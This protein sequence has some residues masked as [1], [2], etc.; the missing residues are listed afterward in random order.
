MSPGIGQTNQIP[1][2]G[3]GLTSLKVDHCQGA[4]DVVGTQDVAELEI[5]VGLDLLQQ[6]QGLRLP[7]ESADEPFIA[8]GQMGPCGRQVP[9]GLPDGRAAAFGGGPR[10][11]CLVDAAGQRADPLEDIALLP[12]ERTA[13][14][15]GRPGTDVS[16]TALNFSS[17]GP[18]GAGP[19]RAPAR[20][21]RR[22]RVFACARS[23]SHPQPGG[24]PAAGP[25]RAR[26][27]T[28]LE[29]VGCPPRIRPYRAAG[30][31]ADSLHT[32]GRKSRG[33]PQSFEPEG[34]V[35]G[36]GKRKHR[37]LHQAIEWHGCSKNWPRS[38][39]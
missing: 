5:A 27:P 30:Q 35:H 7:D 11:R 25:A 31:H 16:T 1:D 15:S 10:G 36:G 20:P 22:H 37:V 28:D 6:E 8:R 24:R 19:R 2:R 38:S 39:P 32:S 23:P 17:T 18:T 13:P 3:T 21:A 12:G 4:I 14:C 9:F 29:P 26:C 33:G 34:L